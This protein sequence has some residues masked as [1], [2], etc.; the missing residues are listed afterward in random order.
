MDQL[1]RSTEKT[2]VGLAL[3]QL[4]NLQDAQSNDLATASKL[5]IIF[6]APTPLLKHKQ[7][8]LT[9]AAALKPLAQA[10]RRI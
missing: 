9:A 7:L 1:L 6:E 3:K 10:V 4:D 2:L 8:K 5:L